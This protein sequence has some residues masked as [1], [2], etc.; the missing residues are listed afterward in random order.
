VIGQ[1]FPVTRYLEVAQDHAVIYNG[2]LESLYNPL[3]HKNYPYYVSPDFTIGDIVFMG[4]LYPA[5]KVRL[6]LFKDQ[7]IILTPR[8]QHSKII[9]PGRVESVYMYDKLFIKH[10]PPAD[11][12]LNPGYYLLLV[13]GKNLK[14]LGRHTYSLEKRVEVVENSFSY[15][16]K[17]YVIIDEK[18]HTVRNR[19]SFTRLYPQYKKEIKKF[20]KEQSLNFRL[21]Q[22]QSLTILARFCDELINRHTNP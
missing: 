4:N 9:D 5:Q 14:L 21:N 1:D 20:A 19:R 22:E 11:A 6:D 3:T 10:T 13:D 15:Q 8:K 16:T 17:Y 2:E 12:R 7:L 18:Y